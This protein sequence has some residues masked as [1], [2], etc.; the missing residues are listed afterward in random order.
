[1]S[2]TKTAL[3]LSETNQFPKMIVDYI[4]GNEKL[5]PFYTYVPSVDSFKQAIED[6]NKELI[7]RELLVKVISQQYI[8]TGISGR[9][10][11]INS[12]LNKNTY[13]VC[14]GHQLCLFTGPL[15]FIYKI[16]TTINLAK[17]LKVHYP[18]NNFIPVYWMASEDHDFEEIKSIN[19][20][21]Q[22]LSWNNPLASGAVGRL[23]T[24][25][26]KEV[27][28]E[29]KKIL[30]DS[31]FADELTNLFSDAYLHHSTLADA[32]RMLVHSLFLNS[33]LIILDADDAE[34]KKEFLSIMKDD[35][36]NKTNYHLV[37]NSIE[38][39]KK[40]GYS[41]QVNPREINVFHL[42]DNNR[43]RIENSTNE[44]LNL[45][46]EEYSP[47]VVL[48]P[49]YQQK[50]LPNLAYIGGPGELAYW[51]E[52]K[53][54]FNHH[55]INFPVLIPRN[56][57]MIIDGKSVQQ[58]SKM[59]I[60]IADLFKDTEVLI[61]EFVTRNSSENISL[62]DEEVKLIATYQDVMSKAV[63]TDASLKGAVDAEM[64]KALNSLK[65]IES[66]LLKAEKQKQ[67]TSINQIKKIKEKVFPQGS[68]QERHD[69]FSPYYL[70][71]GPKLIDNLSEEFNPFKFEFLVLTIE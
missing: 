48:R 25:S 69:N 53:D 30:G 17:E 16:I 57:A 47:N 22:K 33:D 4:S 65:N 44:M 43:V 40:A 66:K 15:Y 13:T 37:N 49:L 31:T 18:D 8:K 2:F 27:I 20:F 7:N 54:M 29:L 61:K 63:K 38:T 60:S 36:A 23:Q 39:L 58:M 45:S 3:S 55:H 5:R 14:T 32:T 10:E 71:T 64:Q 34:L 12:L 62:K 28:D 46:P 42:T 11:L 35:I 52:L 68:L 21:G 26:L 9:Q 41:A 67:E 59:E 56:F 6:K 19:L 51:F 70:K 24:E 1:M 50:I